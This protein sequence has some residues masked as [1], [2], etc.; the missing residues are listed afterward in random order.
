VKGTTVTLTVRVSRTGRLIASG[1]G[2]RSAGRT[3][4]RGANVHLVMR[5]S[6]AG[7]QTL[8]RRRSAHRHLRVRITVRLGTQRAARTVTFR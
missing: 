6:K 7:R 4:K 3:I 8:A 1:R 2:M 5:L